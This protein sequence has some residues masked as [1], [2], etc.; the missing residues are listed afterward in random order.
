MRKGKLVYS[1]RKR[2]SGYLTSKKRRSW[3][4]DYKTTRGKY[5]G[6]KNAFII[7]I[8]L[9]IFHSYTHILKS[10]NLDIFNICSGFCIITPKQSCFKRKKK[11]I[12][13]KAM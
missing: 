3:M 9:L 2:T 6:K 13:V 11:N 12:N 1:D 10:V 4:K 5:E 7:F 8:I